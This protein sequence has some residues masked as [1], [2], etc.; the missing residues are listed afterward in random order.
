MANRSAFQMDPVMARDIVRNIRQFRLDAEKQQPESARA[1]GLSTRMLSDI[2]GSNEKDSKGAD[3]DAVVPN[4][5]VAAKLCAFYGRALDHLVM[6]HP[7]R[8]KP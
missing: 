2:E 7:P 4:L 3:R 5:V 6:A 8:R 1:A